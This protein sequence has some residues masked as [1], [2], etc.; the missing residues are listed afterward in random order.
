MSVSIRIF[1]HFSTSHTM[2]S[3]LWHEWLSH[4][5]CMSIY[6]LPV[7]LKYCHPLK[8]ITTFSLFHACKNTLGKSMIATC[9]SDKNWDQINN[10]H[11]CMSINAYH[12]LNGYVSLFILKKRKSRTLLFLGCKLVGIQWNEG[13]KFVAL[14]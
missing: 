10:L 8:I 9:T 12:S 4:P 14:S 3:A 6:V 1:E 13:L 7:K 11:G 5:Y 2:P